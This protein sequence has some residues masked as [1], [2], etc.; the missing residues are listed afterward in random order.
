MIRSNN[1][2]GA[3]T[4]SYHGAFSTVLLLWYG[5]VGHGHW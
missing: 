2:T 1:H 3:V 5:P 4:S